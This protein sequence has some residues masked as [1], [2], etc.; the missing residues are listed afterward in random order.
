MGSFGWTVSVQKHSVQFR[1]YIPTILKIREQ[2]SCRQRHC[3]GRKTIIFSKMT[4]I[5]SI[6]GDN[7][8]HKMAISF[9]ASAK[10]FFTKGDFFANMEKESVIMQEICVMEQ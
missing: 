9:S 4:E 7:Y 2:R 3:A 6:R 8:G 10:N 1:I 5:F